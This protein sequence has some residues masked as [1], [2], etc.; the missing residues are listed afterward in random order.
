MSNELQIIQNIIFR[1][2]KN[3]YEFL[4]LKRVKEDGD[5]WS[6]LNGTLDANESISECRRRELQEEAGIS[7]VDNW[8][9]EIHRFS[10]Q[11]GERLATVLVYPTMVGSDQEIII[12]EEHDEYKWLGSSEASKLLKYD[13]DKNALE[14]CYKYI[15]ENIKTSS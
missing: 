5:F 13:D 10:F 2:Y 9:E 8:Y 4:I 3:K 6:F 1:N 12:N 7:N 11:Y 14:L 15:I